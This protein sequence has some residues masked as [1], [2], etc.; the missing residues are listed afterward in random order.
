MTTTLSSNGQVAIPGELRELDHLQPGDDF[1]LRRTAPGRYVLE[2]MP[3]V[4]GQATRCSSPYGHDVL[5]APADAPPLTPELVKE[6][7]DEA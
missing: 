7:L 6:L 3:R 2:K 1:E 5:T 4:K